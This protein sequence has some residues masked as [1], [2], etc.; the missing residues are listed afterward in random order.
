MDTDKKEDT[1]DDSFEEMV[2]NDFIQEQD[3]E[4]VITDEKD[5]TINIFKT[6]LN[7]NDTFIIVYKDGQND[8]YDIL[9]SI[10]TI[11]EE[12][13]RIFLK[14]EDEN[15][16]FI[17]FMND[18]E[19]LLKTDDYHILDI[20]KVEEFDI[21][22]L[23]NDDFIITKE[24]FPDTDIDIEIS[25]VKKYSL[26]EKKESLV[27][28]LISLYNAYD[29]ENIIIEINEMVDNFIHMY[30]SDF[31]T[32][33]SNSLHFI[34]E[35]ITYNKLSLP[36]WILPISDNKKR[37]YKTN[38][39]DKTENTDTIIKDFDEELKEKHKL[40]L[41]EK[42]N[43]NTYQTISSIANSFTPYKN[44]NSLLLPYDGLYIRNC[45]SSAPCNGLKNE[46]IFD[47]NKTRKNI[48]LPFT[49]N[50][51]TQLETLIPQ[52]N[53]SIIGFYTLPYNLY[54]MF[55]SMNNLLNLSE[56]YYLTNFKYSY[57]T[58]KNRIDFSKIIPHVI[59]KDTE[60]SFELNNSDGKSIHSFLFSDGVDKYDYSDL[61]SILKYNFFN[62]DDIINS[63]A[64]PIKK[65][66][67]NIHDFNK[68]FLPY[69]I[70]YIHLD[71]EN[72]LKIN[73]LIESNVTSFIKQYNRS[74][75]RKP[76]K[77]IKKKSKELTTSDKINLS[78]NFIMSIHILSI[79]NNYLK[80]FISTF[81]RRP[82]KN[83]NMNY[84]YEKNSDKKLLCKHYHYSTN[85]HND[86]SSFKTLKS[87][88]GSEPVDGVISC[89][90]CGKYICH[91][92][93]STL[94]GFSDG[95]PNKT[96]EVL[97]ETDET[98]LLNEKQISIKKK[99]KKITNI[100]GIGLNN[101]DIQNIID[102][103]GP[104]SD[105]LIID[106]RYATT[107]GFQ[108]HPEIEKIKKKYPLQKNPKS[109]FD[110]KKNI[111]NKKLLQQS[112]SSFKQYMIDCNELI[113][114]TYLILFHLQTSIP[115]YTFNSK[116]NI[117][118]WNNIPESIQSWDEIGHKIDDYLSIKT[119]DAITLVIKKLISIHKKDPFW[120]N[121]N[122]F[123]NESIEYKD[124]P[125]LN[126]NFINLSSYILE[127]QTIKKKLENYFLFKN[128]IKQSYLKEYWSSYKPLFDNKI[129]L[130][131]NQQIND[132]YNDIKKYLLKNGSSITY[133][134]ISS[135][136]SI[137]NAF[138]TPRFVSLNI[139]YSSIMKNESFER[140]F[141]FAIHLH[142]VSNNSPMIDLLINNFINTIPDP[143]VKEIIS[144][145]GWNSSEKRLPK[146]NFYDFKQ[147]FV[148]QL[149]NYF[150]AKNKND[151]DTINKYIHI[152][153]NNWNGMLLNG[154]SKRNYYYYQPNIY[155]SDSY[156]VLMT[157]TLVFDDKETITNKIFEK[158]CVDSDGNI[159]DKIKYDDFIYNLLSHPDVIRDAICSDD[160]TK[161]KD[162]FFKIL[163]HQQ[164]LHSLPMIYHS[165]VSIYEIYDK[166]IKHFIKVNKLRDTANDDDSLDVFTSLY[167]INTSQNKTK[168][169]ERLFNRMLLQK[170]KY[171]ETIKQFFIQSKVDGL[172]TPEQINRYKGGFGR[173]IDSIDI[174]INKMVD[175]VDLKNMFHHIY[176][177]TAKCSNFPK[178]KN[179]VFDSSIPDNWKLS[180]TNMKNL[181]DFIGKNDFLFHY[182]VF[183]PDSYKNQDGFYKYKKEPKYYLCFQGLLSYLQSFYIDGIELINGSDYS[184]FTEEYSEI[185]VQYMFLFIFEKIVVYIENLKDE[186]NPVSIQA[187][188]MFLS[189]EEQ[190]QL[191]ITDSIR[192]CSQY[193]FDLMIHLLEEFS[194]DSWIYQDL[195]LTDKLSKQKEREKQK[196]IDGLESQSADTRLVTVE[197]QNCGITNWHGD[198][199]KGNFEYINS[200]S[201]KNQL[202]DERSNMVKELF[203]ANEETMEA[204]ESQGINTD[205]LAVPNIPEDIEDDGYSQ[206]DQDR[207]D[208]GLDDADDDGNYREG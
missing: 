27:T 189:L 194:D 5:D 107:N 180:E 21:D 96:T 64:D 40:L 163:I 41:D 135:I 117:H 74:V 201:Y 191:N 141:K 91:E 192:I 38:E 178:E 105:E 179:I 23:N 150:K 111:K 124:L 190:Y 75:K 76:V 161:N 39:E 149:T 131:I 195:S 51:N 182:D 154:H 126:S 123:I 127:N 193:S 133:S 153:M 92:D 42:M 121:I 138:V 16:S 165:N 177:I 72:K 59:N 63:I 140:L 99:I 80:K 152:H 113:I 33:Y 69:N 14:D 13:K 207:E 200:E 106:R 198:A 137:N 158:Y 159:K 100:I 81:G 196:L 155:P 8:I 185:F 171:I 35:L 143:R 57:L 3:S 24:I 31:I 90:I 62:Y 37:L 44:N 164:N 25:K 60:K 146:I 183:T 88:Y 168:D 184:D 110:K 203:F 101:Y 116:I 128:D 169:Y 86:S 115:P 197:L 46:L 145:L 10:Q 29:N 82:V 172:L 142:G 181:E 2:D 95:A 15:D 30:Q 144:T 160:L 4:D 7:V 162:N 26:H 120:I 12:E 199:A 186:S 104:L 129:V 52:E 187:N 102:Y 188:E 56:V 112:L 61:G 97:D 67:F 94:G 206:I 204:L 156:D 148:K 134:N 11:S 48:K 173:T 22:N 108:K 205:N 125:T 167:N 34:K 58:M 151:Q 139:P 85:I 20:E 50:Y 175:K 174:L 176:Y 114:I 6:K 78:K 71:I 70:E 166:R 1:L 118:L 98:K 130:A 122:K 19:I 93:F 136:Q 147:I 170:K 202:S 32:D 17:S 73:E 68:V 18:D 109:D 119:L 43:A 83:E 54:D 47:C 45:S 103:F 157:Q 66:I 79:K 87:V 65:N 55:F 53:I 49:N 89:K 36:K 77:N 132:E 84:I 28:E 9:A 208:E